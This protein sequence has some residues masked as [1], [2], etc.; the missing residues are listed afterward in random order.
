MTI[1]RINQ[2]EAKAGR[3][4]DLRALLQS[5]ISLIRGSAGC[6][7][8]ELLEAIEHPDQLAILEVWDSVE[9]HQAAAMAIPPT[10]MQEAMALF[11]APPSGTY[12][13]PL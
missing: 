8:V 6:R 12:F 9:A 11:A 2:F 7:S 4:A 1:T 13:R 3:G 10:K 5:V